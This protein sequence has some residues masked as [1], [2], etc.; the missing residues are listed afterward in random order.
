[1]AADDRG[2]ALDA[3]SLSPA[4]STSPKN[5]IKPESSWSPSLAARFLT[6]WNVTAGVDLPR[7]DVDVVVAQTRLSEVGLYMSRGK[8]SHTSPLGWGPVHRS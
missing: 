4:F 3:D 5:F 6:K 1:L 7:L 8:P 2:S